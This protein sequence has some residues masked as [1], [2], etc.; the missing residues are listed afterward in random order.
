[1]PKRW[2]PAGVPAPIGS[3]SHVAT[4]PANTT[5]VFVSGQVG[6]LRD[7]SLAGPDALSQTRQVFANLRSVLDE[8]GATPDDVVKLLTFVSGTEHL[9]GFRAARDEVF[10]EWY[11]GGDV[12]AHSLAVVAAL[13]A[14]ELTV[15]IEAVIA[16]RDMP[17]ARRDP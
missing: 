3:Y 17:G 2:N 14:P 8:F 15:E 5:L 9:P 4:V 12:P 7:G 13:A 10:A 6:N 1:M 11:P 16:V